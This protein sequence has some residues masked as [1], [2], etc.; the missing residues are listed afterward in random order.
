MTMLD[1]MRRHKNWLKW[2]LA[3]VAV[4]LCIYLIP[5]FLKPSTSTV[6][7]TSREIVADVGDRTVTVKDFD[8]RYQSQIAAYRSQF[9]GNV[10]ES[11]LRQLGIEQQVLRQHDRRAGRGHRSRTPRY[12]RQRRGAGL[13][14]HALPLFDE[15]GQFIGDRATG[16]CCSR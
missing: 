5:N 14:D 3:L 16:R 12:P 2:I 13:A 6:G 10:N 8:A 9:G 15:N 11:I 7:A 1:R 4:S